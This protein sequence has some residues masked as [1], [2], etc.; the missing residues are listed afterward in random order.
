VINTAARNNDAVTRYGRTLD[1][2]LEELDRRLVSLWVV[3]RQRDSLEL[4]KEF[5]EAMTNASVHVVRNSYFG[6]ERKFEL[7]NGSKV[8][9]LVEGKGGRSLTFPDL[10]D[11]VSD[12]L[13]SKRM[14]LGSAAKKLPVG[15][16]AEL[17]RWRGEV[18]KA[19]AEVVA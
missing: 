5:M 19:F 2:T 1:T 7:Y 6:D 17:M 16:R 3:N 15:N 9:E 11:R 14:S 18:R 8:R 4:L 13:Y 12:D 10:A